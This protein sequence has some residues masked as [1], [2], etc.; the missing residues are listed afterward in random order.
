MKIEAIIGK[1]EEAIMNFEKVT[2][3]FLYN[4]YPP[5]PFSSLSL[6]RTHTHTSTETQGERYMQEDINVKF[7]VFTGSINRSIRC[8]LYG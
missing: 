5:P 1:N 3:S 8:Y 4:Y 2:N 6:S 7:L